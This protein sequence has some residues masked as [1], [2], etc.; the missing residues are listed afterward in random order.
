MS[1]PTE[2]NCG[3]WAGAGGAGGAGGRGGGG[4]GGW[5]IGVVKVGTAKA[6]IDTATIFKLGAPGAGGL[7]KNSGYAPNGD[8][9]REYAIEK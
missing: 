1:G 7:G 5:T 9:V 2:T 3:R 8:R 6:T 4:A